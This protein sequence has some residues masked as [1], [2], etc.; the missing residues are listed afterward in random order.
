MRTIAVI[1]LATVVITAAGCGGRTRPAFAPAPPALTSANISFFN[2]TE[3]KDAKSAATVEL[4]RNGAELGGELR[5]VGTH[6][7][8]DSTSGP[9][10][11]SLAGP[12]TKNDVDNARVR[13]RLTPDGKDTWIF[14]ARL[15]LSFADA[16]SQNFFW[17]DI[18]LDNASP[19]R[20]LPLGAARIP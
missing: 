16:S 6:F 13:V 7:E 17:R 8:H 1:A 15:T 11:F 18:R 2:R 19:E 5:A 3:G 9:L 10:A 12:F 20:V 14:D 4:L